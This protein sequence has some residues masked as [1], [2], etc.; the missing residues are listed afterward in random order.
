M[1]LEYK[2]IQIEIIERSLCIFISKWHGGLGD[3]KFLYTTN[4]LIEIF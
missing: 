1:S 3:N 2:K 4:N